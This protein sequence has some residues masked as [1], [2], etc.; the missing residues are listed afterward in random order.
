MDLSSEQPRSELRNWRDRG[1][2]GC[3]HHP[4]F[5]MYSVP[6]NITCTGSFHYWPGALTLKA[7]QHNKA[8]IKASC[9]QFSRSG[10]LYPRSPSAKRGNTHPYHP[11]VADMVKCWG[12]RDQREGSC[13][14]VAL[15][16]RKAELGLTLEP[17]APVV[18][19]L[20]PALWTITTC[21][22]LRKDQ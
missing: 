10:K 1:N 20:Q 18:L 22:L 12:L 17:V 9:T 11:T 5:F 15:V 2:T 8:G 13:S 14:S 3:H 16:D 7:S 19:Y 21:S 6:C 4:C